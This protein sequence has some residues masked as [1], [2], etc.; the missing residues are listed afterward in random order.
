M[1]TWIAKVD[2][3][4]IR[5][6]LVNCGNIYLYLHRKPTRN[7]CHLFDSVTQLYAI[8]ILNY[9]VPLLVDLINYFYYPFFLKDYTK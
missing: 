5:I 4:R 6:H 7:Y 9:M 3:T 1:T 8:H 2:S